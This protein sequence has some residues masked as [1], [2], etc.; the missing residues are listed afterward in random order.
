[1]GK[2]RDQAIKL[3]ARERSWNGSAPRESED[4]D[5]DDDDDDDGKLF[6]CVCV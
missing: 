2:G 6:K 3:V 4:D 1:M 5:D